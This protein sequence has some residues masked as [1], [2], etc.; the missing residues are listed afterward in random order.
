MQSVVNECVERIEK[1]D[2]QKKFRVGNEPKL[3]RQRQQK[4]KV[5]SDRF[6]V[7]AKCRVVRQEC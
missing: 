2:E 6:E 7:N 1:Q 4:L 3:N 5:E